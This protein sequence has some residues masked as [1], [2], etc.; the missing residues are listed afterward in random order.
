MQGKKH[1]KAKE[2]KDK[3]ADSNAHPRK[4]QKVDHPPDVQPKARRSE[5]ATKPTERAIAVQ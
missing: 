1:D 3:A 4:R 2:N 5:R